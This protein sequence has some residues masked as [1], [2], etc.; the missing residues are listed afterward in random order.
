MSFLN[1]TQTTQSGRRPCPPP[2]VQ[3]ST[4]YIEVEQDDD[5]AVA[6]P[7]YNLRLATIGWTPFWCQ[8]SVLLVFFLIFVAI[9]TVLEVVNVYSK[10][11]HGFIEALNDEYYLWTYA[12]TAVFTLILAFWNRVD[13]R[14]RQMHPWT[15]LI[16]GGGKSARQTVLLNYI[17]PTRPEICWHSMRNKHWTVLISSIAV[18]TQT[19]LIVISTALFTL[20][21]S[22]EV[23]E[24]VIYKTNS[25]FRTNTSAIYD[26]VDYENAAKA[27]YLYDAHQTLNLS[28]PYGTTSNHVY[29]KFSVSNRTDLSN[30]ILQVDVDVLDMEY[31]C[32]PAELV[33]NQWVAYTIPDCSVVTSQDISMTSSGCTSVLVTGSEPPVAYGKDGEVNFFAFWR[34]ELCG[35]YNWLNGSTG[36]TL[37]VG[38]VQQ[39]GT[40][41]SNPDPDSGKCNHLFNETTPTASI[42]LL[43]SQSWN[44]RM[45]PLIRRAS[46]SGNLTEMVAG[47]P[48][49]IQLLAEAPR[50]LFANESSFWMVNYAWKDKNDLPLTSL[51]TDTLP[52]NILS[53]NT[54]LT[55]FMDHVFR[56]LTHLSQKDVLE[57]DALLVATQRVATSIYTQYVQLVLVGSDNSEVAGSAIVNS[58]RL[59]VRQVSLIFITSSLAIM[60]VSLVLLVCLISQ[61]PSC[62][63]DPVSLEGMCKVLEF[64]RVY[65]ATFESLG[66]VSDDVL[67]QAFGSSVFASR[68]GG[69]S[70][71]S[72]APKNRFVIEETTGAGGVSQNQALFGKNSRDPTWWRPWTIS[73]LCRSVMTIMVV[74]II[75]TLQVLLKISS[76]Q[77]GLA[78]VSATNKEHL[79]WSLVPA[80]VLTGIA[81]YLGAIDSVY[82]TFGPYHK[83]TR[84]APAASSV[85]AHYL[86]Q[87]RVELLVTSLRH[88]QAAL[89]FITLCTIVSSFFT[90]VVSGVFS[91]SQT[92]SRTDISISQAS[93]FRT[94]GSDDNGTLGNSGKVAG[95]ILEA[96]LSY[97]AWTFGDL[98][99]GSWQLSE[100]QDNIDMTEG[101]TLLEATIPAIRASLNCTLHDQQ[102]IP[103]LAWSYII[104]NTDNNG[105]EFVGFIEADYLG[106]PACIIPTDN[107]IHMEDS[108]AGVGGPPFSWWGF[109]TAAEPDCPLLNFYWGWLD[110][111]EPSVNTTQTS[112][113]SGNQTRVTY[114]RAMSCF[115]TTEQV[116]VA[117]TFR[118]PA[119]Q[120][121]ETRPPSP[122]E[123]TA[124]VF[125][126]A[127]LGIPY[128]TLRNT[129][130]DVGGDPNIIF[131]VLNITYGFDLWDRKNQ[132]DTN[133]ILRHIKSA[134]GVIRAQQ[135]DKVLRQADPDSQYQT[136]QAVL[137]DGSRWRLK[138]NQISTHVLC[139][140]LATALICAS[141]ASLLINTKEVLPKDPC[142]IAAVSTLLADSNM[143][144]TRRADLSLSFRGGQI[145]RPFSRTARN[146][147]QHKDTATYKM[148]FFPQGGD[149]SVF[150]INRVDDGSP[151]DVLLEARLEGHGTATLVQSGELARPRFPTACPPRKPL[152]IAA[153][154]ASCGAG[155]E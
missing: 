53:Q 42:N 32:E 12:P 100:N 21:S 8:R 33:V 135:Y 112:Q 86:S 151:T 114:A 101:Q 105:T 139:G 70:D 111:D 107:R 20:S 126:E 41:E 36:F 140:L 85:L 71:S 66:A 44:C 48:P 23:I 47:S 76:N 60:L 99:F 147:Q 128:A 2:A 144:T 68:F 58:D 138:Q 127:A 148:A 6:K 94:N 26:T 108:T 9:L 137:V 69:G 136:V 117:T 103:D 65:H 142:T 67:A 130:G 73:L 84:G 134:H 56:N 55:P 120:I 25:M 18:L 80:T 35:E 124:R 72:R 28:L 141:I 154:Q 153:E 90:I 52:T 54:V 155:T 5:N 16:S 29:Q 7:Q 24:N 122:D 19:L 131:R 22:P 109:T 149:R 104:A 91:P 74:M 1:H 64:S 62:P 15:V 75:V 152:P 46:L 132:D 82:R 50:R 92:A 57:T 81:I 119:F 61:D 115:E 13:Y 93:W 118:M 17:S 78:N 95:L 59:T 121:D 11:H 34:T 145:W 45:T 49:D 40:V 30:A 77:Q 125:S 150:T 97:P 3:G 96:N 51:R 39:S 116:N 98:A 106:G 113:W 143:L 27:G 87:T 88:Q 37:A 43:Q 89:L 129:G 102:D 4:E 10:R 14:I 123:S 133:T 110:P 38:L 146:H 31:D 79:A 83:L 63:Y